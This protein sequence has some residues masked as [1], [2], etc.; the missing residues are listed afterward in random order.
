MTA[1]PV[2]ELRNHTAD[3]V[4]RVQGGEDI[5]IT[6]NGVAVASLVP[7]RSG[8]RE[9]IG[10]VDLIVLLDSPADAGLRDDLAELAGDTT[11]EL[12]PIA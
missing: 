9:W 3:V 8:R 5:T 1:V 7:V 12:G 10:P 4:R 6:A 11:D 2:R